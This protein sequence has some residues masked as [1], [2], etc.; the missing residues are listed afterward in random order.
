MLRTLEKSVPPSPK[1]KTTNTTTRKMIHKPNLKSTSNKSNKPYKIQICHALRT[2]SCVFTQK[3][4]RYY[5]I[6]LRRKPS[7]NTNLFGR[8]NEKTSMRRTSW[9]LISTLLVLIE[10]SKRF[11]TRWE[12][13]K[14][15]PPSSRRMTTSMIGV[16]IHNQRRAVS[17]NNNRNRMPQNW[18]AW[19]MITK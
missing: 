19:T 8:K 6:M 14:Q 13:G 9:R 12:K 1:T 10:A 17:Q 7:I 16:M 3:C 18:K 5:S 4:I 11:L 15:T 2:G